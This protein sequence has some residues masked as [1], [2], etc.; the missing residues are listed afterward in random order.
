MTISDQGGNQLRFMGPSGKTT[1][2]I[3]T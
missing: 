2:T 1:D 3:H